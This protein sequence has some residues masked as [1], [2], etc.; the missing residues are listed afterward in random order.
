MARAVFIV[1]AP[2][3]GGIFEAAKSARN[4]KVPLFTT[5]Y[6][7]YPKNAGGNPVILSSMEGRPVR[8]RYENEMLVLGAIRL[9]GHPLHRIRTG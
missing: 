1:E 3:E 9:A 4:L 2:P 6:A 5:A 8:G 7:D